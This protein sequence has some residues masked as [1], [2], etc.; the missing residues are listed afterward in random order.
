M[1]FSM[2]QP[3]TENIPKI[4]KTVTS[5][6]GSRPNVDFDKD[7][8][9]DVLKSWKQLLDDRNVQSNMPH[10]LQLLS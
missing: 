10:I 2:Q 9:G 7:V 3:A 1:I 6:M 8:F 5:T 4:K